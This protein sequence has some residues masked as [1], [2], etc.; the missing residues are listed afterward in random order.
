M[1]VYAFPRRA[2]K[3]EKWFR[4]L[5]LIYASKI[6]IQKKISPRQHEPLEAGADKSV[7]GCIYSVFVMP[8]WYFLPPLAITHLLKNHEKSE[9]P[10]FFDDTCD[11]YEQLP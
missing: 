11:E 4:L 7:Q 8:R 9:T 5:P 2:W 1:K 10:I 6:L 3:R